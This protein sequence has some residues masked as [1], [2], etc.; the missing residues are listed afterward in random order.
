MNKVI[1]SI[2]F[3][4]FT[5]TLDCF[6]LWHKENFDSQNNFYIISGSVNKEN[7]FKLSIN[8]DQNNQKYRIDL[9]DKIIIGDK[10]KILRYSIS[11]NQL[12]IEKSDS[13][14]NEFMFSL[15]D[16]DK[17]NKKI[18]KKGPTKYIL[19]KIAFGKANIF[20]NDLCKSI[21]SLI[22][23]KQKNK[24]IFNEID[25]SVIKD[26]KID[27]LFNLNINEEDLLKYDFR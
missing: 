14:F 23:V 2:F 21:D 26:I 7:H 4:S 20:F 3:L 24:I 16:L 15:L 25:V 27:S 1:L 22:Y 19:K 18:K 11:T 6:S 8:N 5:Y 12:F 10:N 9:I 13:V 17:I